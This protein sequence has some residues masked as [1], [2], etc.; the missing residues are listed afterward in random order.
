MYA[1]VLLAK[2]LPQLRQRELLTLAAFL[3]GSMN[4]RGPV[5]AVTATRGSGFRQVHAVGDD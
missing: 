4:P 2:I 5:H 3:V 1:A